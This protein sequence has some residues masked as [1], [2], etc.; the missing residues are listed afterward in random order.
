MRTRWHTVTYAGHKAQR[1]G[2]D[3]YADFDV[4]SMAFLVKGEDDH[5]ASAVLRG[6]LSTRPLCMK[7]I[8]NEII[9]SANCIA[10]SSTFKKIAHRTPK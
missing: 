3:P 1:N 9:V 6:S 8:D 7:N 10:R 5:D 2:G 4:S